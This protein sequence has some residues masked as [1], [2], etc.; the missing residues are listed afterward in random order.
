MEPDL[1]S[2]LNEISELDDAQLDRLVAM[3]IFGFQVRKQTA[4]FDE[5]TQV[6]GKGAEEPWCPVCGNDE[7]YG[8][9]RKD[10]LRK[11]SRQIDYAMEAAARTGLFQKYVLRKKDCGKWSVGTCDGNGQFVDMVTGYSPARVI[12]EAALVYNRLQKG[13]KRGSGEYRR[14]RIYRPNRILRILRQ[15]RGE[16][17]SWEGETLD[18]RKVDLRVYFPKIYLEI[19]GVRREYCCE[20]EGTEVRSLFF[21]EEPAF[22]MEDILDRA[23]L[24]VDARTEFYRTCTCCGN[25]SVKVET[26]QELDEVKEIH[27][28]KCDDW[29]ASLP[30]KVISLRRTHRIGWEGILADGYRFSTEYRRSKREYKLIVDGRAVK[31]R[32]FEGGFDDWLKRLARTEGFLHFAGFRL[33][34]GAMLSY[35]CYL[36]HRDVP[37]GSIEDVDRARHKHWC[38]DEDEDE[39]TGEAGKPCL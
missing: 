36:C 18:G 19:D 32:K 6:I 4:M 12:A 13:A 23:N 14:R 10:E 7:F 27:C 26:L 29:V 17:G 2:L 38:I 25:A 39:E 22:S 35:R 37:T 15:R 9:W 21:G 30:G 24:T 34:E 5:Y 1:K 8:G 33:A 31:W 20:D 28:E 11:Y 16:R 3:E